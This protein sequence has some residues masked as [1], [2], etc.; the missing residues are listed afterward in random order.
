MFPVYIKDKDF[1]QP[2]V[3]AYYLVADNGTFLVKNMALYSSSTKVEGSHLLTQDEQVKL[4]FGMIP[5]SLICAILG[6]FRTAFL[7][8]GGEAIVFLYY[9]QNDRSFCVK[10]PPQQVFR[11]MNGQG[12]YLHTDTHVTYDACERPRQFIK[13]GTIHSHADGSAYHSCTDSN[14][15][16]HED[17]LH[18][19][20]GQV[21]S[22]QPDFSVSFVVN[23]KRFMLKPEEILDGYGNYEPVDPPASWIWQIT[24]IVESN[25][26]IVRKK[27]RYGQHKAN[28][29][30]PST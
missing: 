18:I 30:L 26:M 9:S 17:G 11:R 29:G 12:M 22:K 3:S 2:E 25:G 16:K 24:C 21:Q 27:L 8:H 4:R 1:H 14:D 6:F 7:W 20:I 28:T 23:G 5:A 19:T 13:L 15:E 10:V